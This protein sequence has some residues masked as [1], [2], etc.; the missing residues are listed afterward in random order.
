MNLSLW[1]YIRFQQVKKLSQFYFSKI[2][3]TDL[4]FVMRLLVSLSSIYWKNS[5][6]ILKTSVL[7]PTGFVVRPG[8]KSTSSGTSKVRGSMGT[9]SQAWYQMSWLRGK[10]T[11][12]WCPIFSAERLTLKKVTTT[13]M[14]E[15]IKMIF[16]ISISLFLKAENVIL[17]PGKSSDRD[18]SLWSAITNFLCC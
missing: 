16:L 12:S 13:T 11:A 9:S 17:Y 4:R 1:E 10:W 6:E 7:P 8:K 3:A 2:S 5:S 18:Q 14:S 15:T